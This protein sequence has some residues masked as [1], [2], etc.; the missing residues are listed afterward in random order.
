MTQKFELQRWDVVEMS[1]VEMEET[2]GGLLPFLIIGAAVLLG[3]CGNTVI[4]NGGGTNTNNASSSSS[5]SA[6]S[7]GNGSGNGNRFP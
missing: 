6:D 4:Y 3:G 1:P 2:E 7:S 5:V